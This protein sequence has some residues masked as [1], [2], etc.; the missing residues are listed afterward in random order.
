MAVEFGFVCA[1]GWEPEEE[2]TKPEVGTCDRGC[3]GDK[4]IMCGK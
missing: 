3:S 4:G 2:Y 1:C